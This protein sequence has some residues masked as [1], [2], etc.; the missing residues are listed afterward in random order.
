MPVNPSSRPRSPSTIASWLNKVLA[1]T[2][3]RLPQLSAVGARVYEN[4][5]WPARK[6]E[7][8]LNALHE[9]VTAIAAAPESTTE[10][11]DEE[12]RA[13][14]VQVADCCAQVTEHA[15]AFL[16][17]CQA[18]AQALRPLLIEFSL[19]A[20]A[21]EKA[22]DRCADWLEEL[23][24]SLAERRAELRGDAEAAAHA[25]LEQRAEEFRARLS[26]LQAVSRSARNFQL[27][28]EKVMATRP[29]LAEVVQGQTQRACTALRERL[30]EGTTGAGRALSGAGLAALVTSRS[31]A[32][33]WVAQALALVLRLQS[34]QHR[35]AK[36]ASSLRHRCALVPPEPVRAWPASQPADL[37]APPT[38]I[39]PV[40]SA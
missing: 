2:A 29:A 27:L 33:I 12:L 17:R 11:F 36:E 31:D 39:E 35:L 24:A 37:L 8:G 40:S 32:Q 9:S 13:R 15:G 16:E 10:L 25:A 1:G 23:E 6:I 5:S 30:E 14:S 21:L 38:G 7:L 4:T 18:S 26:L 34:T 22:A 3:G 28:A 20:R 19:E